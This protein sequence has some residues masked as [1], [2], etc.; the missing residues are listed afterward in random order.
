MV[1]V[2]EREVCKN[3]RT[4]EERAAAKA[5]A[6]AAAAAEKA[7]R[8]A[9]GQPKELETRAPVKREIHCTECE[10]SSPLHPEGPGLCVAKDRD[11][12]VTEECKVN[13]EVKKLDCGG[14]LPHLDNE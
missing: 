12:V 6:L 7:A 2:A 9:S 14:L 1:C 11:G 4:A 13:C 3:K 8:A 5:E 10:P